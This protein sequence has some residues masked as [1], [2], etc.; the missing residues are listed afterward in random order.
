V[1]QF[2]LCIHDPRSALELSI[3][4]EKLRVK[5]ICVPDFTVTEAQQYLVRRIHCSSDTA[6]KIIERTGT[7]ALNL[8]EIAGQCGGLRTEA[9]ILKTVDTYC[10]HKVRIAEGVLS[11]LLA[12]ARKGYILPKHT[13]TSAV[14]DFLQ[15][16][17][18]TSADAKTDSD[19]VLTVNDAKSAFGSLTFEKFLRVLAKHEAFTV[20]PFTLEI[21]MESHFMHQAVDRLLATL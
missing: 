2:I 17:S 21:G 15:K 20:D 16:L 11:D 12:T 3:N 5:G 4:I 19:S 9:Q 1:A 18:K 6:Q 7:R 8:A 10:E 14:Y 13:T